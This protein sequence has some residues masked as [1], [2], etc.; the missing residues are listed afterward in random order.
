MTKFYD[1]LLT[2]LRPLVKV[3]GKIGLP[4]RKIT[5]LDYYQLISDIKIGDVLLTKTNYEMTNLVNPTDIK[6]AAIYIGKINESPVHYVAEMLGAGCTFTDLVTFLKNKDVLVQARPSFVRHRGNFEYGIQLAASTF[7]GR[8]YDYLFNL[9]GK[10]FYCFELCV[11]CFKNVYS[12]LQLKSREV[13][14]GKRI[15]DENTFLCAT[16]FDVVFDSRK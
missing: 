16:F 3:L 13:V 9:D 1:F 4:S 7:K 14:K 8:P 2:V 6:H 12:E 5:G 15:Y 11:A 10:A